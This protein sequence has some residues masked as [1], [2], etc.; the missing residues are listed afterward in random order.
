MDTKTRTALFLACFLVLG[1][2]LGSKDSFALTP[3]PLSD[4]RLFPLLLQYDQ[5]DS[6][7]SGTFLNNINNVYT[8]A[9]QESLQGKYLVAAIFYRDRSSDLLGLETLG[10]EREAEIQARALVR[11]SLYKAVQDTISEIELLNRIREYGRNLS[12]FEISMRSGQLDFQG[13]SLNRTH[14]GTDSAWGNSFRSRLMVDAGT[15]FGLSIQTKMGSFESQMTYFMTGSDI[16]GVDLHREFNGWSRLN[17][18]YRLQSDN[19]R[20]LAT[21]HFSIP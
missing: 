11:R 6:Q 1:S 4:S 16:L 3:A 21:L 10:L 17:L 19:Q 18:I 9:F 14:Q 5:I 7:D 15:E 2:F 13:P 12:S 8:E 20:A